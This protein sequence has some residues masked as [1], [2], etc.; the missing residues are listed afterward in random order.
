[1]NLRQSSDRGVYFQSLRQSCTPF[2]SDEIRAQTTIPHYQH[3]TN[4]MSKLS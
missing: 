1:M 3:T 2:I 4:V